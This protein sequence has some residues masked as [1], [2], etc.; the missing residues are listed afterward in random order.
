MNFID[1]LLYVWQLPQNIVGLLCLAFLKGETRHRLGRI[2]FYYLDRFPG[3]VTLGEYIVVGTK[4]CL[5]VRHEYGHVL[6]SRYLGPLYLLVV[7]LPSILHAW[8]HDCKK[9][10][11]T[12]YHFYTES[13]ADRLGNVNR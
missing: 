6:Q 4:D 12:Y 2:R 9:H 10:G 3:G 8:I 13:W 5:T 11:L 7:G 1:L